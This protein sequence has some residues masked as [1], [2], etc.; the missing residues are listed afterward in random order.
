MDTLGGEIETAR[1]VW[2][3][4][5][6]LFDKTKKLFKGWI[7][8]VVGCRVKKQY[9]AVFSLLIKEQFIYSFFFSAFSLPSITFCFFENSKTCL[10]TYNAII[11]S[12]IKLVANF[13]WNNSQICRKSMFMMWRNELFTQRKREISLIDCTIC[14]YYGCNYTILQIRLFFAFPPGVIYYD[15][16][17]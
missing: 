5:R 4:N 13:N 17:R 9:K 7:L 1:N 14:T 6:S 3:K 2:Y 11:R 10:K 16:N 12:T 15:V 8:K